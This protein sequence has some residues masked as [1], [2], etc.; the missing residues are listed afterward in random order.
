M[1]FAPLV[2]GTAAAV[3]AM[4]YT[5]PGSRLSANSSASDSAFDRSGADETNIPPSAD[6]LS[7]YT[8]ADDGSVEQPLTSNLDYLKHPAPLEPTK[9]NCL[10]SLTI[11]SSTRPPSEHEQ[12]KP[13]LDSAALHAAYPQLMD[14]KEQGKHL[15]GRASK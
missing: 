13:S 5:D 12:L 1:R 10:E 9:E 11:S 4:A 14:H 8:D 15:T 2:I 3:A 7:T 6:G